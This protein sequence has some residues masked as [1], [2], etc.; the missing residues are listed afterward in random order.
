[1][2]YRLLARLL[3]TRAAPTD[4]HRIL[5]VLPCCIGD[6]VLGT[7]TLAALRRRY[8]HAHITWAVGRWSRPVLEGH[9]LLDALLDTGEAALPVK[10][11]RAFLTFVRNVRV[12]RYDLTVSLVRSPLMSVALLLA[13]VPHR[14]GLDSAGRGFGYNIRA[15]I[16]PVQPRHEADVY[17]DVARVLGA[18]TTGVRATV[19]VTAPPPA[20]IPDFLTE[21]KRYIVVHPGG[22]RNPGMVM[23][24]KRWPAENVGAL[25]NGLRAALG[26][27]LEVVLLYGRDE[28][29]LMDTVRTYIE[30]RRV[31]RYA[32][33]PFAQIAALARNALLYI[34][35]DTGIT[36]YAA[37]AGARTVMILGPSDPARYAPYADNA[38][39]LWKPAPVAR[40]GVAAGAPVDW[41]WARDGISADE[42]LRQVLA[43]L[44]NPPP[45]PA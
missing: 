23:D 11:P 7:A 6:V 15:P 17:L 45:A 25:V 37:A 44:Q 16:S 39:A 34:G 14:A 10:S 20:P 8:P 31:L 21:G 18:D 2:I 27:D 30:G 24:I 1:M 9:P 28:G 4:P 42:A 35:N 33:L 22:G 29:G 38:I 13:G 40:E 43:F 41:D 36:H 5:L 19:P 12:G 32:G 3:P 26:S